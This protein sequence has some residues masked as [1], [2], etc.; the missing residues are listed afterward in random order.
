MYWGTTWTYGPPPNQPYKPE[1][2]DLLGHSVGGNN[3]NITG[4]P[5]AGLVPAKGF[6]AGPRNY[7]QFYWFDPRSAFV[8]CDYSS[9][10]PGNE[11]QQCDFTATAY[12]YNPQL[13]QDR[14][15]ATQHWTQN[16]CTEEICELNQITFDRPFSNLSSMSFYGVIEGQIVDFYMDSIRLEWYDNSCEAGLARISSR[17]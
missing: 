8:Q 9:F 14:V 11:S 15:V 7:N 1:S 5:N 17:K 10:T 6:G 3:S 4:S 12:Q 2:G 13:K 16:R